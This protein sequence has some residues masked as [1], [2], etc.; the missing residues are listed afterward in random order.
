MSILKI[1]NILS[2]FTFK[3][4]FIFILLPYI[5]CCSGLKVQEDLSTI[6]KNSTYL[7][8]IDNEYYY[9][10]KNPQNAQL[11]RWDFSNEKKYIYKYL[12]KS[13][14]SKH[15]DDLVRNPNDYLTIMHSDGI[16]VVNSQGDQTADLVL[17]D[18]ETVVK[19]GSE[20][21][22]S[23]NR[24]MEIQ[25]PTM[26]IQG[27]KEDGRMNIGLNTQ[28][29]FLKILFPIPSKALKVGEHVNVDETILFNVNGNNFTVTGKSK[30]ALTKYVKIRNRFCARLE[31]DIDISNIIA[32][33]NKLKIK[34]CL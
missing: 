15:T 30:I 33:Q 16:L 9:V 32:V 3:V 1:K 19:T 5:Y 18:M 28:E 21:R 31:T 27:M 2:L 34:Y 23:G 20:K 7:N 12:K 14:T 13:I 26:V 4:F 25:A 8:E 10:V 24:A 11:L 22:E 29:L 6:Q 17:K